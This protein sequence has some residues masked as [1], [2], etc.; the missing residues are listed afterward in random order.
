[1]A[2]SP[3]AH[4]AISDLTSCLLSQAELKNLAETSGASGHQKLRVCEICGAYLSIL[5]SDRRLAD[6]FG[7]KVRPSILEILWLPLLS[8][9]GGIQMHLGYKEL[10]ELL[11]K[12]REERNKP[13][14]APPPVAVSSSAPAPSG[15]AAA[16]NGGAPIPP[17]PAGRG[18]SEHGGS[19][20]G[21]AMGPPPGSYA[22]RDR[23]RDDR[24]YSSSSR[25]DDRGGGGG[26]RRSYDDDRR[27]SSRR[28]D[29]RGSSRCD[30][31][32][33]SLSEIAC[34]RS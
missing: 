26:S 28:Y 4:P 19:A 33:S 23:D 10:R 30:H 6:H 5:D 29:D 32:S 34:L 1:M 11:N 25:Y 8:L 7:G 21:S 2:L 12:I 18:G 9:F 27:E 13:R 15:P 17:S 20:S 22:P 16:S 3:L 31:S 24:G 14:A